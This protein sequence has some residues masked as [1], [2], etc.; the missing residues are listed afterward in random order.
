MRIGNPLSQ[1][2]GICLEAANILH[3]LLVK[4]PAESVEADE[5][6][7]IYCDWKGLFLSSKSSLII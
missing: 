6:D 3:C 7:E 4:L 2:L 1:E 5:K